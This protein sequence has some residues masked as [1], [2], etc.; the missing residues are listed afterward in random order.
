MAAKFDSDS[1]AAQDRE[2]LGSAPTCADFNVR[3]SKW[4]RST[5]LVYAVSGHGPEKTRLPVNRDGAVAPMAAYGERVLPPP[6]SAK[7][8][9]VSGYNNL[10]AMTGTSLSATVVSSAAAA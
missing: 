9:P 2:G 1:P 8:A 5:P 10:V 4:D 3:E 7:S 6:V